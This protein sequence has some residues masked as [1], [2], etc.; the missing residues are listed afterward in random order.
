M[1]HETFHL[2]LE[3]VFRQFNVSVD[4]ENRLVIQARDLTNI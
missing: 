1:V 2:I 3:K 4:V